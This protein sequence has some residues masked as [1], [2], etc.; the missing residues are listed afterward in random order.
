MDI[1]KRYGLILWT[2]LCLLTLLTYTFFHTGALLG[3]YVRPRE[4]GYIAAFGIEASIIGMA[5]RIG[6]LLRSEQRRQWLPV[7]GQGLT[8]IFV[9]A[10]SAVANIAEG[11]NVKYAMDLTLASI[12]TLD[13]VQSLIG[14]LATGLIPVVVLSMSEIVSGEVKEAVRQY[15]TASVGARQERA[16]RG[17]RGQPAA[18]SH[19]APELL[20]TDSIGQPARKAAAESAVT[21]DEAREAK[22]AQDQMEQSSR[23]RH[24]Y[25]L[26]K[27]GTAPNWSAIARELGVTRQTIYTDRDR[28][29]SRGVIRESDGQWQAVN[30]FSEATLLKPS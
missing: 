5:V 13:P 6:K 27:E 25:H 9:L 23:E 7:L 24:I 19:Q 21:I 15:E 20:N 18:M 11:F 22:L 28:L 12:R 3:E 2:G 1:A 8:L 17:V 16:S 26:V 29:L 4:V 14:L 10:V 30:G